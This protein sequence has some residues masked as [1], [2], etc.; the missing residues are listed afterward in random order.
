MRR[1]IIFAACSMLTLGLVASVIVIA[2]ALSFA[3]ALASGLVGAIVGIGAA[4][5]AVLLVFVIPVLVAIAWLQSADWP[6][7]FSL[8]RKL[9]ELLGLQ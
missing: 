7:F 9:L 5:S 6:T 2:A 8:V 3:T 1:T 4:I